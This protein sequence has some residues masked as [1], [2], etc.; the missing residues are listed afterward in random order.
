MAALEGD[1][2][3]ILAIRGGLEGGYHRDYQ[4]FKEPLMRGLERTEETLALLG[5]MV[6]GLGVN[7]ARARAALAGD[8]L[9][10][11]EVMRRVENGERFRSAYRAVAAG[12]KRGERFISP[13]AADL[14]GRRRST[15]GLG[16]PGLAVLT[17]RS[18][19]LRRWENGERKRFDRAIARLAGRSPR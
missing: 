11:D 16:N 9:A 17:R 5:A 13:S 8:A 7:R 4:L 3:A 1:L 15:G 19:A 6:P 12:L 2:A 14:V 18:R 10:T